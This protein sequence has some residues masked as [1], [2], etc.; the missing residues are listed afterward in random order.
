[1]RAVHREVP[2][3]VVERF[4]GEHPVE[5]LEGL[6]QLRGACRGWLRAE[7]ERAQLVGHRAP[8]DPEL[9]PAV[10]D[11]V[12]RC[13]H[14]G[15]QCGMAEGVAQH[16]VPDAD[17][18]GA[19]RERARD[20]P[21]LQCV[22]LGRHRGREVVHQPDGVEAGGLGR[23]RP[24]HDAVERPSGAVGGTHQTK[25]AARGRTLALTAVI[26]AVVFD[27]DGVILDTE[28]P[29]FTV[30]REVFDAHGCPP[31]TV[32]EW[33][34]EIGTVGGLDMITLLQ[35]RATRPVDEDAMHEWRRAR[36]NELLAR[37][38]TRP[39]VR[40]WLD[41]AD[42]LGLPLAIAS[43][44]PRDWVE[45]HLERLGLLERFGRVACFSDGVAPKP[46]PDSYLHACAALGVEPRERLGDR[47][48]AARCHRGQARRGC[49]VFAV[50]HAITAELDLSH[51][52]AVLASLAGTSLRETVA[53]VE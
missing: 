22:D 43:S 15:E 51:A 52:D 18:R 2:A 8:T 10:R 42:A 5:D 30:W 46:A 44:S 37:E 53:R 40:E 14:L 13:G 23:E 16:E 24:L 29:I 11:H 33:S 28:G 31:L 49:G 45:P 17:L 9:E 32:Q 26:R 38:V 50:P 1:M 36:R 7:P 27:F 39:G 25:G 19:C 3:V 41:E 12:E 48:F 21:A 4:P 47:G 6:A 35:E 20:R 34:A